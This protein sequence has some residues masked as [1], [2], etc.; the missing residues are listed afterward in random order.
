MWWKDVWSSAPVYN[1]NDVVRDGSYLV[2]ARN[3]NQNDQPVVEQDAAYPGADANTVNQTPVNE[4]VYWTGQEYFIQDARYIDG[5]RFYTPPGNFEYSVIYRVRNEDGTL[6]KVKQASAWQSYVTDGWKELTLPS[7]LVLDKQRLE[8]WLGT[9]AVAQA[10]TV[11]G[12]WT[13]TNRNGGTPAAGEAYFRNNATEIQFNVIDGNAVDRRT[14]LATIPVGA[15]FDFGGLS[16]TISSITNDASTYTFIIQPGQG[17]PAEGTYAFEWSWGAPDPLPY[18]ADTT[19]WQNNQ[20]IRGSVGTAIVDD[21]TETDA[22][23]G[24]DILARQVQISANWDIMAVSGVSGGGG[25]GGGG[26]ELQEFHDPTG[27]A[28]WRIVG[29]TLEC[30]GTGIADANGWLTVTFPKT[31]AT[32]PSVSESVQSDTAQFV[33]THS[34]LTVTSVRFR[35]RNYTDNSTPAFRFRWHA[36]GEW[37]GVS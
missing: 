36:I 23:Y 12:P 2:I 30:W 37:D 25:G 13:T 21:M 27:V 29:K 7:F 24:V 15:S 6:E 19:F 4:Q 26:S 11:T 31:F 9:R 28:S 35:L 14:E 16:W 1:V 22:Q 3:Q 18:V 32:L 17:R 5:F 34:D 10:N 8:I 20:N 33:S